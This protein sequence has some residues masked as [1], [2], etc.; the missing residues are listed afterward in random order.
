M[1]LV[2]AT[3]KSDNLPFKSCLNF[4]AYLMKKMALKSFFEITISDY[5]VIIP[6]ISSL[7]FLLV[8]LSP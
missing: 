8:G 2:S 3:L 6:K 4:L 1:I 7:L 5:H